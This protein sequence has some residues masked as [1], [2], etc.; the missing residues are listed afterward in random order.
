MNKFTSMLELLILISSQFKLA[1][2]GIEVIYSEKPDLITTELVE[3]C[4]CLLFLSFIFEQSM[5]QAKSRPK[6]TL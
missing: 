3:K 6:M 5:R 2:I 4:I 1:G